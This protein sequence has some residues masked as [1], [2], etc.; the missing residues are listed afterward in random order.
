MKTLI[1]WVLR[2]FP[3]PFL[4]RISYIFMGL[5]K[6]MLRGNK[7]ECPVCGS[8]FRKFLPYGVK[9][10]SNV[11]C[12]TCLS[13]ERHRLIWLYLQKQSD[14]LTKPRK[15]LHVAPE[16]CFYNRFKQYKHIEYITAD[17]ES[18]I[19]D[20]HFDL[21][22]IPFAENSFDMILC[23]H[24]LEHVTDDRKVMSEFLRVLRPGGFAILQ[25]P[26]EPQRESTYEDPSITDPRQREKFFGQKDHV[27]VYGRDYPVR[28]RD[29]GFTVEERLV[30]DGYSTEMINRYRLAPDETLY[31]ASKP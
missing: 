1:R 20:F 4:I 27:R 2:I 16:Q 15:L 23:N 19:A 7:V 14:F 10:R 26:L 30:S 13:L 17:L 11:L 25:V 31:I 24:V 3:R 8:T 5:F 9:S 28:L 22:E 12:P 18:P 21:H 29:C 6:P